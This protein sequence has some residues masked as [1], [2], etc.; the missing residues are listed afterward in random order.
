[1]LGDLCPQGVE[2]VVSV[3]VAEDQFAIDADQELY[4]WSHTFNVAVATRGPFVSRHS[5]SSGGLGASVRGRE[6]MLNL[7][8]LLLECGRE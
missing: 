7:P 1:M 4:P 5:T 8:T 6:P 3:H 2:G